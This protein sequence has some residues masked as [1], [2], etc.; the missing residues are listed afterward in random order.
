MNVQTHLEKQPRQEGR[1]FAS[2]A[3]PACMRLHFLDAAS[4]QPMS[5]ERWRW[6]WSCGR[7]G[8]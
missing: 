3:C 2:F 1:S 5:R 8:M 6:H 7:H 4:G